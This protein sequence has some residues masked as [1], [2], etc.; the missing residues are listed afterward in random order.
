[1]QEITDPENLF[2]DYSTKSGMIWQVVNPV[3]LLQGPSLEAPHVRHGVA[4]GRN[5]KYNTVH[6]ILSSVRVHLLHLL[7]TIMIRTVRTK[8]LAYLRHA[9]R[10]EIELDM[11][12]FFF[13]QT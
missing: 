2:S 13:V 3:R 5:R 9:I 12:L 11:P 1:M 8:L 4:L 7:V 6:V 10:P